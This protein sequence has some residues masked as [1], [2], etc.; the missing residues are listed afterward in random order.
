MRPRSALIQAFARSGRVRAA[1][2]LASQARASK[3]LSHW[4][5]VCVLIPAASAVGISSVTAMRLM[6]HCTL[7]KSIWHACGRSPACFLWDVLKRANSRFPNP[8]LKLLR[9][10]CRK[11]NARR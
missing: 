6:R 9:T 3:R 4:Q 8:S 1:I 5:A 11:V 2:E 10:P 7:Q